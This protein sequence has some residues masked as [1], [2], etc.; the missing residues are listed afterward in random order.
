M[1]PGE[2]GVIDSAAALTQLAEMGF[3]GPVTPAAHPKRFEGQSRNAIAKSAGEKL[4]A[5]W[6]GAGL[7]ASGK[8][9]A[10]AAKK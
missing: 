2:T 4:D 9:T 3:D 8:L 5:V 7:N 1:L 6:K 10:A